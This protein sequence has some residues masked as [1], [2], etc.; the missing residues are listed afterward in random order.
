M[1][2]LHATECVLVFMASVLEIRNFLKFNGKILATHTH[3]HAH[4]HT[5][6]FELRFQWLFSEVDEVT[7]NNML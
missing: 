1:G 3:T 4:T 5:Y 2:G 7:L 6:T